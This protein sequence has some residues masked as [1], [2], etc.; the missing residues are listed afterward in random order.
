MSELR[1][2]FCDIVQDECIKDLYDLEHGPK[3]ERLISISFDGDPAVLVYIDRFR[4]FV[5]CSLKSVPDN[6]SAK[7]GFLSSVD[8]LRATVLRKTKNKRNHVVSK[9]E[10]LSRMRRNFTN[11]KR[12]L[13]DNKF[14]IAKCNDELIHKGEVHGVLWPEK[15]C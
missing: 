10:G 6:A 2:K 14:A 7:K 1:K 12:F 11:L 15:V 4:E 8:S 5:T 13:V 9:K 3:A